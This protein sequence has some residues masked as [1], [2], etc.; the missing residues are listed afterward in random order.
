MFKLTSVG[1]WLE[2]SF[3]PLFGAYVLILL[4]I[5]LSYFQEQRPVVNIDFYKQLCLKQLSVVG[6]IGGSALIL[7]VLGKARTASLVLWIPATLAVGMLVI[8]LG[9]CLFL[10]ILFIFFGNK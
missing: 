6:T 4:Y 9:V 7:K 1:H 8:T 10:A 2:R 5:V 3:W